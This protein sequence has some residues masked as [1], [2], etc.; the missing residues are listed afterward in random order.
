M[1]A[2]VCGLGQRTIDFQA[3]KLQEE[4]AKVQEKAQKAEA[5]AKKVTMLQ[6]RKLYL[7]NLVFFFFYGR[8]PPKELP[9]DPAYLFLT[10]SIWP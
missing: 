6:W 4:A 8:R 2:W 3:A 10:H 9:K 7:G 5:E 1:L